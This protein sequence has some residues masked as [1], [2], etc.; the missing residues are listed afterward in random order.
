MI[1]SSYSKSRA[2]L[3]GL[4]KIKTMETHF[5]RRRGC[6]SRSAD[7]WHAAVNCALAIS[8]AAGRSGRG[9]LVRSGVRIGPLMAGIV[10]LERYQFDVWGDTVNVAARLTGVASP[11]ALRLRKRCPRD[12]QGLCGLS[13]RSS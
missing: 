3:H 6:W 12:L 7:A 2:R 11:V 10:G 8:E 5:S 13:P 1:Y 4:E 9:W